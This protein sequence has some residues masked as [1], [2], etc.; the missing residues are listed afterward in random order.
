MEQRVEELERII[1]RL[2]R[3]TVA[4][5]VAALLLVAL[6]AGYS[7]AT[8]KGSGDRVSRTNQALSILESRLESLAIEHDG[9]IARFDE[10]TTAVPS[11]DEVKAQK[12]SL[13]DRSGKVIAYLGPLDD[14]AMLAMYNNEGF[15]AMSSE[16]TEPGM[17][18]SRDG[19]RVDFA[20]A[21][22]KAGPTLRMNGP[23]GMPRIVMNCLDDGNELSIAREDGSAAMT[24]KAK[25]PTSGIILFDKQSRRRAIFMNES[26]LGTSL[27]SIDP[28]G[29]IERIFD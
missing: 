26:Q 9:L 10:I 5:G 8:I 6:V 22:L 1:H 18:I 17:V 11:N 16:S 15:V 14:G 7:T 20:V 4:T 29:E 3:I 25:G 23:D 21:A 24:L 2:R 19:K 28:A 12:F 13:V 27:M